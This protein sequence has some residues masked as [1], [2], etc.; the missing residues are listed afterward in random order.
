M[1]LII[2]SSVLLSVALGQ[3]V[4]PFDFDVADLKNVWES[5]ELQP[6]LKNLPPQ[7]ADEVS[8]GGRILNGIRASVGQFPYYLMLSIDNAWRCGGSLIK[9]NWILTVTIGTIKNLEKF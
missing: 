6:A 2:L 3:V 4:K 1:K 8:R 9:S 5:P 7:L